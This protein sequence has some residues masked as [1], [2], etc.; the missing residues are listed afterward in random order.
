MIDGTTPFD[1]SELQPCCMC[2]RGVAHDQ[3]I[4]F[5]EVTFTQCA[6]D[7][8]SIRQQHGLEVMMGAAAPLAAVF[9]P[10]TRV[11]YRLPSSRKLICAECAMTAVPPMVFL[12]EEGE[13]ASADA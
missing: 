5:Y 12:E 7:L 4:I 6:L 9:A 1:R 2:K 3:N 13:E 8:T 11:A 10:T